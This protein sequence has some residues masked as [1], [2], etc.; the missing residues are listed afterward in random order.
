MG[1][2]AE[3]G[4]AAIIN[5][6]SWLWLRLIVVV[7]ALV[8]IVLLI[9]RLLVL[10]SVGVVLGIVVVVS[11]VRVHLVIAAHSHRCWLRHR[12]LLLGLAILGP[13]R[14]CLLLLRLLR[15]VE[16][17]SIGIESGCVTVH[18]VGGLLRGGARR[19]L[20][21]VCVER[22]CV[23]VHPIRAELDLMLTNFVHN[24]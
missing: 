11:W 17:A 23:R 19:P 9:R 8:I 12:L 13:W 15:H 10:V 2:I 5:N 4:L 7:A 24:G 1:L 14:G 16:L 18:P 6:R 20:L 21:S 22:R 3:A